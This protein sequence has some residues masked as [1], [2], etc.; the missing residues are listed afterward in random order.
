MYCAC[1]DAL[2]QVTAYYILMISALSAKVFDPMLYVRTVCP[3]ANSLFICSLTY[4]VKIS[5]DSQVTSTAGP[6]T[7]NLEY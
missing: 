6:I 4:T 1:L 5:R 7:Y 2:Y 3:H